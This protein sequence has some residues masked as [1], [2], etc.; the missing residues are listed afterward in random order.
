MLLFPPILIIFAYGLL[1]FSDK[2]YAVVATA[3]FVLIWSFVGLKFADSATITNYSIHPYWVP[4][5]PPLSDYVYHLRERT[6]TG[7]FLIGFSETEI[8]DIKHIRIGRS[9]TDYYLRLLAGIDGTFLH[10]NL[11]RY[12]LEKDVRVILREH[13]YVLL[14]YDPGD[15]PLNYA[16]TIEVIRAQYSP[17][18]VLVD[19]PDLRI[20]RFAHPVLGCD[21]DPAPVEY[22]NGIRILDHASSYEPGLD[23]I[24]VLTWWHIPEE[25]MLNEFN[26]SLQLITPQWQNLRQID[27]HLNDQISPWS[28]IELSTDNLAPGEY[29]L[30]LIL[31]SRDSGQVLA[32]V[33]EDGQK[34]INTFALRTPNTE[35]G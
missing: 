14:A 26:I 22:I 11:K 28:V 1:S 33:D 18:A 29:W 2:R 19:N 12:R 9:P 23:R 17:C 34:I 31:Y 4:R 16:R 27:R 7:D 25:R 5:Y 20:Q 13:P 15:V 35:S 10:T 24:R 3:A 21:H 30:A 6:Q 32:R 8:V